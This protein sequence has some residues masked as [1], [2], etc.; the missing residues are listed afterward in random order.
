MPERGAK[1]RFFRCFRRRVFVYCRECC[2]GNT[3]PKTRGRLVHPQ[4]GEIRA[5]KKAAEDCTEKAAAA[6]RTKGTLQGDVGSLKEKISQQ[7]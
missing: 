6:K 2:A 5:F 4:A 1:N 7:V 3:L